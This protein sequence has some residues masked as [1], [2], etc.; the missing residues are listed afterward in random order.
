M[1]AKKNHAQNVF[2][3]YPVMKKNVDTAA[4]NCLAVKLTSQAISLAIT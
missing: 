4:R 2:L 1:I 3:K